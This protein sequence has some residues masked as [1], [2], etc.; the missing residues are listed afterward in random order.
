MNRKWLERGVWLVLVATALGVAWA[1]PQLRDAHLWRQQVSPG[2]LAPAHASLETQCSTCH[3]ALQSVPAVRCIVCHASET[4]LLQRQA[5]AFHASIGTCIDCHRDHE[6]GASLRGHMDHAALARIG[7]AALAAQ[8]DD[9]EA[10]Q[11]HD[12]LL[13]WFGARSVGPAGNP[14]LSL[15]ESSLQC[16]TCHAT[17]DRHRGQFGT[18]CAQCHAISQW[19]LPEFRHPPPSSRDCAQCHQPPPSH[20]MEHFRM[21]SMKVAGRENAEVRQ[22]Y[23][24]HRTTSWN[25]I[26]GVGF[27]DHH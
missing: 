16:A 8:A 23:L 22:C 3:V 14:H 21:V 4:A 5:T 25:D 1:F 27:Y 10:R 20:A 26:S 7:F 9:S 12:A 18:D 15:I 24:C 11:R 2:A 13:A 19:T 17:K 6:D